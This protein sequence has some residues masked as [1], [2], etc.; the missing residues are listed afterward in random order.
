MLL[1]VEGVVVVGVGLYKR[2]DRSDEPVRIYDPGE[3]E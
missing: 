2:I 3:A 1:V